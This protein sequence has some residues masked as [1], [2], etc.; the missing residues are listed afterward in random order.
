[1]DNVPFITFKILGVVLDIQA[2]HT[3][4][5]SHIYNSLENTTLKK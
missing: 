3:V 2:H 5:L 1:M 4:I